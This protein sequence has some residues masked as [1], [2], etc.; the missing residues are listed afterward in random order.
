MQ[1]CKYVVWFS[2]HRYCLCCFGQGAKLKQQLYTFVSFFGELFS[3][4]QTEFVVV[5]AGVFPLLL[6]VTVS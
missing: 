5:S 6:L 2:Y 3:L 1:H 4:K